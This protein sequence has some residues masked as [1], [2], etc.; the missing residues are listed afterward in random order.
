MLISRAAGNRVREPVVKSCSRVPIPRIR[1][2]RPATA[3]AAAE[4]SS[5]ACKG[6]RK[7]RRPRSSDGS[8]HGTFTVTRGYHALAFVCPTPTFVF[9]HELH[10]AGDD[11]TVRQLCRSTSAPLHVQGAV[12]PPDAAVWIA[13][14]RVGHVPGSYQTNVRAGTY[15]VMASTATRMRIDR[16]VVVAADTTH[17]LDLTTGGFDLATTSLTVEMLWMV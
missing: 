2:A 14:G 17:D 12:T 15:D 6:W 9:G 5:A 11:G 7:N 10:D 1:S 3:F 13:G 8:G 16:A 4:P